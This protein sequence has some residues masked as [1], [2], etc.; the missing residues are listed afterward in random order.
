MRLS[1][2]L[3]VQHKSST[4]QSSNRTTGSHVSNPVSPRI[5]SHDILSSGPAGSKL[6]ERKI[7][8][9]RWIRIMLYRMWYKSINVIGWILI[10]GNR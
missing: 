2:D 6:R 7:P 1:D 5:I 4:D 3:T 9:I 8:Y 10:E